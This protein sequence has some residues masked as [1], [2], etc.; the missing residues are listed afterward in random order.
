MKSFKF[1][2]LM[3]LFASLVI[4]SCSKEEDKGTCSDGIQN[5]D[6][7][8][9]DCGGVCTACL[10]GVQGTW[11]SYPVAPILADF[12][13]SITVEFYTNNTYLVNNYKDGA[14]I[15]LTGS[16]IQTK[17][18]VGNIYNIKLN[19]TSPTALT[20][21]GIFEVSE[22]NNSMRYEVLQTEPS[23]GFNPPTAEEGFGSTAGGVLGTANVQEYTRIQ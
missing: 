4:F 1:F 13:D 9:V 16:Y 18:G 2:G 17:S 8:G 14:K 21:E 22:D 19:Q 5:Q 10:E 3:M 6:E 7:T 23:L 20:S 15:E 12:S 11:R